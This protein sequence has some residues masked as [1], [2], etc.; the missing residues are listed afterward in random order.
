V[1]WKSLVS[2]RNVN[3][4]NDDDDQNDEENDMMMLQN[5]NA[6]GNITN[7]TTKN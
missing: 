5:L 4:T 7:Q 6:H 2:R 3:K 1:Y